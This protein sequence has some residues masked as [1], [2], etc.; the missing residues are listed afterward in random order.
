MRM[1]NSGIR[2]LSAM[3]TLVLIIGQLAARHGGQLCGRDHHIYDHQLVV[4]VPMPTRTICRSMGSP[5]WA[6]LTCAAIRAVS[7]IDYLE[8]TVWYRQLLEQVHGPARRLPCQSK[9]R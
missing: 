9:V 7:A 5:E 2:A 6:R 3:T 8:H 4:Y 1:T